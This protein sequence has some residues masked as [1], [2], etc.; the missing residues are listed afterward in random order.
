MKFDIARA[1]KDEEYRQSLNTEQ[2][3]A[4]PANPAGGVELSDRQLA[5]IVGGDNGPAT[6]SVAASAT[7]NTHMSKTI[8]H[9]FAVICEVAIF[10]L[11][12][13]ILH[14]DLLQI[15]NSHTQICIRHE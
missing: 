8:I 5:K 7:T 6:S 11:D 10:S 15:G 1:W 13:K 2:L 12:L 3:A 14:L 4:L 9:S